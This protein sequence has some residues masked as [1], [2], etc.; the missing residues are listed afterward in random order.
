MTVHDK[1]NSAYQNKELTIEYN[2]I[3][4]IEATSWIWVEHSKD[5]FRDKL[6]IFSKINTFNRNATL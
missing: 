6:F 4:F 5:T 3:Y 1:W 2:N